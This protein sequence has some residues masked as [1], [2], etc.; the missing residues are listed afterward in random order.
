MRYRN[1]IDDYSFGKN[2][3]DFLTGTAAV[4]QAI[5]TQLLLLLGE[6]WEDT[7]DGLPLF[8]NIL[9]QPGTPQN[10]QSIDLLIKDRISNTLGVISV[11]D[12]QSTYQNRQYSLSC[13]VSTQY[14]DATVSIT[15]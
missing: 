15:F 14:G 11:S 9:G 13:T 8:E 2:E 1:Q 5:K 4:S 10:V 6:W 7:E 12:F 3:Q